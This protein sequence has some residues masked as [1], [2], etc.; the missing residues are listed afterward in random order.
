M[1]QGAEVAPEKT[2]RFTGRIF[3]GANSRLQVLSSGPLL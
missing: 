3:D 2:D 1:R